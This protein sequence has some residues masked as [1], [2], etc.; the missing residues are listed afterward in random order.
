MMASRKD[1]MNVNSPGRPSP[2]GRKLERERAQTAGMAEL[3]QA[4][5]KQREKSARLKQL[6]LDHEAAAPKTD[7]APARKAPQSSLNLAQTQRSKKS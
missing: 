3:R 6:R 5:E 2:A 4:A 1:N 7:P